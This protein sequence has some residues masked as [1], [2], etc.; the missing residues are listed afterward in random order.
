MKLFDRFK[1]FIACAILVCFIPSQAWA[2]GITIPS[3]STFNLNTGTLTVPGFITNAGTL[4]ATTGAINVSGNWTNSGTFS[5]GTGT[6]TF[7]ATSGTQTLNTGGTGAADAFYNLT[8]TTNGT[9]SMAGYD[10]LINNNFTNTT[11]SGSFLTNNFNMTVDGNWNNTS[12]STFTPGT[13]TV[14]L[15][16]TNQSVLGTTTFYQFS[17]TVASAATLTFDSSGTQKFTNSLTMKGAA[18]NLLSIRS[19]TSGTQANIALSSGGLQV[20]N[21]LDVKDSNA[22]GGIQLN[23]N[24]GVNSGNNT[25]WNFGTTTLT[26]QGGTSTAWNTAAN[27]DLGFVPRSTDT[28]VIAN[29]ANQPVL[30]SAVTVANLTINSGST[31]TLSG[32]NLT[33][34]AGSGTFNNNGTLY[35]EGNETL[36]LTMDSTHGTFTYVGVGGGSSATHTLT[37]NGS[38]NVAFN[39]LTINDTN[40]TVANRD[41]FATNGTLTVNGNLTVTSGTLDTSSSS[42]SIAVT[43]AVSIASSGTLKAPPGTTATAFTVGGNWTNSGTFNNSSGAVTFTTTATATITGNTTFYNLLSTASGKTIDFTAGSNQT[44]S[45]TFSMSGVRSNLISLL[46]TTT[47]TPWNITLSGG[48]QTVGELNVQDSNALTNTVTCLNCTNSGNN[49]ANWIFTTLYIASPANGTTVGQTP[50]IIGVASASTTIYIRDISGNLVATTKSDTSGNFR[51]V[52][53]NDDA[54]TG[55]TI[56]TQLATGSNSLTPYVTSTATSPGLINSLTVSASPSTSQIPTMTKL[57][58]TTIANPN[59]TQF[60]SGSTPAIAGL[61]LAGQTVTVQALDANSN[62]ILSAGSGTVASDGTYSVTLTTA[63]PS[64]T[65]Y[66][67]VTV[68]TSSTE[69]TSAELKVS[70]TDP[71]GYVYNSTTNL[72]IQS[73]SVTLYDATTKQAAAGA[74]KSCS[75]AG[76]CCDMSGSC[77]DASGN[78]TTGNPPANPFTTGSDGFYSFLA[79]SGQYY[80]NVSSPGYTYPSV[81]T[82]VPSGRTVGTGS[83]GETFTVGSTVFEL[84]QPLDANV[85]LLR[86]TKNANK[87]EASIGDIVMY[88]VNIQ[89][90]STT[91]AVTGVYLNDKIPPGFKYIKNRVLLGGV[92]TAEPSG[93]RPLVFNIGTV[94]AAATVVLKYQL[95][96]GSGVTMGTYKNVAIAQYSTGLHISNQAETSVKIIP[97]PI[98]DLGA[99]IGK[100]FFDWNE[101]GI[102]DPPYYDPVSHETIVDKPVPNVQIIMEDGTIITT[103]RDGKFN[104]PGLLPG[105]HLF[106]LDER[107]L[108]PGAYMTTD[109][110]VIVDVTPGSIAKVNFGV[111]IDESQT[112]G[113]DAVFFNEKIRLTQDRNRPVPRLNAALFDSSADAKPGTEEVLLNEGALVRQAEFRIFTNYSPFIS[114]WR[115]DIMDAD[116][117]KLIKQFEGTPL[118]IN[119]PIYWNG[120]DDKDIIINP[121]HKYSYVVSVTDNRGNSD[122][123]KEKPITVREI[124][125]ADSLKKER[126]ETKDVLKDRAERYRKWLD[127]QVAVN[128]LNHQLIQVQ[129]ETIHLDRQGTDVKSIRVMKGNNLFTDIPLVEQYGLTPEELM[130]GGFSMQD[131]KDNLEIILPNGDYSLDV[132]SAKPFDNSSPQNPPAAVPQ[133]VPI[134]G[135]MPSRTISSSSPGTLE[136]YSRPLKVGDDYLMFVALGDAKVGYNIDRGNIEPIQDSTQLPGFYHKGKGAFYLKGQILGKYLITSS[137]DSD[138]AQKALFRKL[139]PNTYYPV[140]GDQSSINYDATN[141]QGALYLLVQWDKSSAILGN[142]AVDFND[143]EFSAFSRAYYGGKIDYQSVS[144]NP[145]GDA[146]TKIVVYHAQTQ[147]LPSH[148]EFLATGG[149]LYFLKYRN[150]VQGSD[151]VTVQVRDAT[152]GL[153]VAT[154]TMTNGADYELDNSQGR[155]LFWLPV[156]MLVKTENIISNNLISGNPIYVVVDYQYAVAGLQMQTS[157]GARI[158]QAIGGNVVLGGTYIQDNANGQNYSLQGTDVTLHVNKDAAVKAE[159][160]RTKSQENGSYVSTDGGITFSSLVLNN[161]VSGKAYG[162]KGDARLFDNIGVKSYYK[163]IGNDFGATDTTSQQGKEMM[164]LS[165]VFDMTPVTRLTASEDI[166]KLIQGGNLQTSAQVGA[167][168]TDTTMVQIVHNAER[169]KLTGQFQ[170]T[171]VKSVVNGIKSTTNQRGATVAGQAQYDLTDRVKLTLGQQVD[172]MN[173][174]NTATTVG[175]SARVTDQTTLNGQEV[176]SQQGTA[177][178]GGVTNQ[179]GK[180]IALTNNFTLTNLKTGEVDK[181]ASIGVEDKI[182]NNITATGNAALTGS[183]TGSTTTT[184]SVGA[185]AKTSDTTSLDMSLGK[186]Q[187]STGVQSTSLALNG[188]AQVDQNTT[189]TATTQVSN[190]TTVS[191][192]T[193][194]SVGL[195]AVSKVNNNTSTNASVNIADDTQG[196]KSTTVT[197]GNNSKLNQELQAVTSNSFSFSPSNGT[198]EGS[199]Y[200]LVRNHNGQ[201]LEADYT[202]QLANQPTTISQSNIFGL[203]GD[204]NDKLAL[205]GSIERGKVQNL[206]TSTTTR[207]DFTLGAGY[208]LKDTVTAEARLKNSIK[209]ELRLDKGTNTDNLRQ[210]VLYDALEGK[211][212]DN[213]SANIKL[214]Y[215]KTRDTT[216]GRTAERHKEI[217]LGMAYRPVNFDNLNF[218]TE[219]SYQEGYGG[220]T[221]QADA[222]N[223]NVNQTKTQVFSAQGVYD[224]NDKW[225]LA[226][227]LAYRILNEQ[228]TGFQFTQTHTWLMIHRL[229]YKIDRD[230]TISGEFR[231]LAQ[232]EAKDNKA[233]LLLEATR[234]INQ[235][236]ELSIG[237]NFTKYTDDL[238]NLSYSSQGPFVRMS[239]KFYDRT[240]EEKA[241]DRAKWLDARI[242]DWAWILIRKELAKKDSKIALE[243]NRMFA[244]AKKARGQGR[245][246]ESRQIYKDIISAGQM[247]YDEAFEYIRGHI[248]F[249]EQLQQ[250]DKTAREYFKGGEYVKARKIWEKVVEDVSRG[251]VKSPYKNSLLMTPS[252]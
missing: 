133:S 170:L 200:G 160:A 2:Q 18:S 157:Q 51:V 28:V 106:R 119:D 64:A 76:T 252:L 241:R 204:V 10:I 118:N 134:S 53:G 26:W 17:K 161:S 143:T 175:V 67:S 80:I 201:N 87:P 8:H 123:T 95:V 93:Q 73:A 207:T 176:F 177:I 232:V 158:A 69:T 41:V 163:W 227:K 205:K 141:T 86:I 36:T 193:T 48:A 97:N 210:Y 99:V 216:A 40:S 208:V 164:G 58:G 104:I 192:A 190:G 116:T 98:F 57:N 203:S 154:Q 85:M 250:D 220:G 185:K 30:A 146:R 174:N 173:K 108:P 166:Q 183:S 218:I 239:G 229:N 34:T 114:S 75:L 120:Q 4:S 27:W 101:N 78:T 249:E 180:R 107:T 223:T 186:S 15:S 11:S 152:T 115:L 191:N 153:V 188:T 1:K 165:I 182:N 45:H 236:T 209:L 65:N 195:Q 125:D 124:K 122:D 244:L 63:L 147:Q 117:Q 248:A 24:N 59:I 251:V 9:V 135:G 19:T 237:W 187:S 144:N 243:L 43:G 82:T 88:T 92:P 60:I 217:I 151:T 89:N 138:R 128:N 111:N 94:A 105:R 71:F 33:V 126:D 112:K 25:N 222:L 23:D 13:D 84:D 179:I 181:T 137:Y 102:Q 7:N 12:A 215:S 246:E 219:Y 156:A 68:G 178:T 247:M 103:D 224:I 44:V 29:A 37:I 113:R 155:I 50:T 42:S 16:G 70:L 240:P 198:T 139:D 235:N 81:Q 20:L 55:L 61:G 196:S 212:T 159:Y 22:S 172:V 77:T 150:V 83:K 230:W 140:Y 38:S 32:N 110:A 145:Y 56:T 127:A 242:N 213:L 6:V 225:Q 194:T 171:E 169:L 47:G 96:I 79:P 74:V 221:Q 162:I 3:G 226:E 234:D 148:N 121:D 184:A 199:Q 109:K 231:D 238:T 206:D 62:L 245:L 66:L 49:N 211:I 214:D 197:F 54:S 52:V 5:A 129:G 39:N 46:S 35:L 189:V 90:L 100:V 167:S 31:L 149:S 136:R 14:A 168:E 72:P 233:G 132:I 228:D 21:Y 130:A 142:Y 202:R 131:A 91:N